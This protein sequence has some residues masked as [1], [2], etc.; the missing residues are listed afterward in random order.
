MPGLIDLDNNYRIGQPEIRVI[1][2]REKCRDAGVDV[3]YLSTLLHSSI[4][5]ALAGEYRQGAFDYD[6]RVRFDEDQ[7]RT[8]DAVNQMTV[9]N[10][11]GE[12]IP[13]G[14]LAKIVSTTGPAQLFRKD[15]Q[16]LISI[17]SD[18]TQRSAGDAAAD[19]VAKHWD[20]C[21]SSTPTAGWPLPA[22]SNTW[23]KASA[24]CSRH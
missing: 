10:A 4:E 13:L 22:I 6:I 21:W 7:R 1:P 17:T 12:L 20:R 23:L 5:G 9:M 15:R 24:G 19:M 16:S 14:Q 2:D 11:R 8:V 3:Q 18:V